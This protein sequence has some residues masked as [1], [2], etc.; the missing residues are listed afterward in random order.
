MSDTYESAHQF[1]H[2]L[3]SQPIPQTVD[4]NIEAAR[5]P[6]DTFNP[7]D[8]GLT[9]DRLRAFREQPEPVSPI[10][11]L[12]DPIPGLHVVV[13][14]PK[15]GKTT[16]VVHLLHAWA[17]GASPWEGVPRLEGARTL[18]LSAEQPALRVDETGRRMD[19]CAADIN[20]DAWTDGST[21]IARRS[22]I[23]PFEKSLLTFDDPGFDAFEMLLD[24]YREAGDPVA[25]V[26]LDSLSRLL[27]PG[28]SENSAEELSP[29]LSRLQ[30][31]AERHATYVLLIHHQGHTDRGDVVSR[32]R[33]SSSISAVAQATWAITAD[34]R[35]R[36]LEISGNAMPTHRL[37]FDV[38][39]PEHDPGEIHYWRPAV[40][41]GKE[42][43]KFV[44]PG[45]TIGV[46]DL[47]RRMFHVEP[48]ERPLPK[49]RAKAKRLAL[50]AHKDR[51]V[52]FHQAEGR[53]RADTIEVLESLYL[54]EEDI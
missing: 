16:F 52:V 4:P 22:D 48:E 19:I 38:A 23:G 14:K 44:Q 40:I 6:S 32:A 25:A 13:G 24:A 47:A 54:D 30:E 7:T 28:V 12:L 5:D 17:A 33:G 43:L 31:I 29:W 41:D 34:T 2:G 1:V 15:T 36:S 45:E 10:R 8:I 35:T 11:G 50:A 37:E 39:G 46:S 42:I 21:L 51:V 20:R 49:Q 18:M 26:G 9:G 3:R 53:G 27:P